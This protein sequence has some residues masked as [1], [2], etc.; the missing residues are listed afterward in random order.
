MNKPANLAYEFG[1]FLLNATE[2]FLLCAGEPVSLKPKVFDLLLVLVENSGH[3]LQKEELMRR[4]WPDTVVEESNLTVNIFSLRKALDK[5]NHGHSYIETV[6]RLGYRFAAKI[7]EV[8]PEANRL[9]D[10]RNEQQRGAGVKSHA[11]AQVQPIAVLPFR[12][13]GARSNKGTY[14]GLGMAD[15][16]ITRISNLRQ[17]VVR[18][19]SAVRRYADGEVDPLA[20]G[21]ELKVSAVLDGSI[22]RA[23]KSIRVTVQLVSVNDGATLWAEK[24]DENFTN[25]FALE[26]SISEQVAGALIPRLSKSERKQLRKRYTENTA[27]YQAYLKGRFFLDK[28]TEEGFSN[29]IAYF[30]EAIRIDPEYALAYAGMADYYELVANFSVMAPKEAAAKAKEVV[31]KALEIDP[32]LAEAHLSLAYLKESSEW[33]WAGAEREFK[34]AIK[35]K[36]NYA[37]AHQRYSIYLRLLGRFAEGLAEI[38]K[39]LELDPVSLNMNVSLGSLLY[40]A[41]R[42]D[43]AIEQLWKTVELD[44]NFVMAHAYLGLSFG[45]KGMHEEAIAAF[46][47]VIQISG[48]VL[49]FSAHL[50]HAYAV[51]GK[52]TEALAM[53]E[54][55]RNLSKPRLVSP[56]YLALIYAGLGEEDQA[57]HWLEKAYQ[58]R[59]EDL[60]LLGV[61]QRL[62]GLRENSWFTDLVRRLG[63][64]GAESQGK[65][66]AHRNA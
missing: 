55:L 3:V 59:C 64:P 40:F 9:R 26:D 42:Y 24:F 44:Q 33:D 38:K 29:A 32:T 16:L 36:P 57:R 66:P 56:Y 61:D 52:R 13:F 30:E 2:H 17:I 46:R 63:L 23:G 41:R 31:N 54:E 62:D 53:L 50:A 28:R 51:A 10:Q 39:A 7:R 19:T 65:S 1:P 14:L 18:P 20:A 21:E 60:A 6:P 34:L 45:Q 47:R 5:N 25:I 49:E 8:W 15:A 11:R 43:Q 27:A 35:L 48:N 58:E 22:R 4:L 12:L 37:E